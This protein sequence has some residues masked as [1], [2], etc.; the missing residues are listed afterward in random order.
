MHEGSVS[1]AP[2]FTTGFECDGGNSLV[3]RKAAFTQDLD[4]LRDRHFRLMPKIGFDRKTS[5]INNEMAMD[6]EEGISITNRKLMQI[7]A[8]QCAMRQGFDS[9]WQRKR[10]KR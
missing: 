5:E 1:D 10:N 8:G 3:V 4:I 7:P 2:N 9:R 6:S